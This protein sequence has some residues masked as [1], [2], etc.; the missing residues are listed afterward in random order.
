LGKTHPI[1]TLRKSTEKKEPNGAG[2]HKEGGRQT[3]R[4]LA[5]GISSAISRRRS[6][7]E[8]KLAGIQNQ[9]QEKSL[10]LWGARTITPATKLLSWGTVDGKEEGKGRALGGRQPLQ[11]N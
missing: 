9:V 1:N 6:R 8:R 7:N 3:E 11:K 5:R 10:F 4:D 2:I